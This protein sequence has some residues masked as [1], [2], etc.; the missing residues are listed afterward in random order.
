MW[1]QA[2]NDHLKEIRVTSEHTEGNNYPPFF[3]FFTKL[4]NEHEK[5]QTHP[6]L[7]VNPVELRL[8]GYLKHA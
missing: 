5:T 3:F 6:R 2:F 8:G 4:R 7:R 1:Q